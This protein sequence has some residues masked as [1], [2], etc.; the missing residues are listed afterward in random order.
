MQTG[1][2]SAQQCE[3]HYQALQRL[4]HD[5]AALHCEGFVSRYDLAPALIRSF[6]ERFGRL[7]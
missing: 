1:L 5:A 7:P 6:A 4:G 3:Q 2:V